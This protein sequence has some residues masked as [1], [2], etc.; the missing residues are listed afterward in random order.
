MADEVQLNA[1]TTTGDKIAADE[2]AGLKHQRVKVQ[3]GVDDRVERRV[4]RERVQSDPA[5]SSIS[6]EPESI[7]SRPVQRV[8]IGPDGERRW[9]ARQG[10]VVG[11]G[12]APSDHCGHTEDS[13]PGYTRCPPTRWPSQNPPSEQA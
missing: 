11:E 8:R 4:P 3:V 2:I 9:I 1:T 6:A 5:E 10:S 13:E 12:E 7:R